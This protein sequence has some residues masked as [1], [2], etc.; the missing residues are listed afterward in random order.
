VDDINGPWAPAGKLPDSFPKLPAE[1]NRKDMRAS[2]PGK[3]ISPAAAPTVF[4]SF[5]PAK[6][7]SLQREPAYAPAAGTSLLWVSNTESDLFRSGA[8]GA[9]HLEAGRW[10]LAPRLSG[11]W[12]FATS[13]ARSARFDHVVLLIPGVPLRSTPGFML[14]PAPRARAS[15]PDVRKWLCPSDDWSQTDWGY[16]PGRSP[17]LNKVATDGRA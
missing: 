17:Q 6:L 14:P 12:T 9:F 5:Q 2:L 11:P 10:L 16:A 13:V 3:P 1:E 7:I 8:A 15:P 4:V